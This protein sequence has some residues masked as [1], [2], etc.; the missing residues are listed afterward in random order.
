MYTIAQSRQRAAGALYHS[1]FLGQTRHS[2]FDG[3]FG[4]VRFSTV[5]RVENASG[6][7]TRNK[8]TMCCA[9]N[10]VPS[11]RHCVTLEFPR[12]E[13]LPG[14]RQNFERN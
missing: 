7:E 6:R 1:E 10:D 8:R 2:V 14:G 5:A 13:T 12:G 9:E 3:L 4:S 11:E